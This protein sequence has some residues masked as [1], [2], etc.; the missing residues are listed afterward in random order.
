MKQR[1][2]T[3]TYRTENRSSEVKRRERSDGRGDICATVQE[4]DI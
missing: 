4:S 1:D 3:T 2:S